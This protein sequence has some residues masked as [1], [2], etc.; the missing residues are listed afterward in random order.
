MVDSTIENLSDFAKSQN[1]TYK[2]LKITILGYVIENLTTKM[3]KT[4]TL[5]SLKNRN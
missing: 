3:A 2:E 5:G 1:I 4:I